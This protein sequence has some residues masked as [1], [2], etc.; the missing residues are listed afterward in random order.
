MPALAQS[1]PSMTPDEFL[2]WEREQEG[3]HEFIEGL[4]HGMSGASLTHE[5]VTGNLYSALRA[6]LG[7]RGCMVYHSGAKVSVE[8][9]YFYPDVVVRCAP[10]D[11]GTNVIAAP[12][13]IA[14]V[15]SPSTQRY[16]QTAK[17]KFYQRLP[18]LQSFLMVE[19]EQVCVHLYRRSGA[20]WMYS[21][22]VELVDVIE[23]VEPACSLR[24]SDLYYRIEEIT[25]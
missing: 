19:Q 13:L 18:T 20:G 10:R 15:L 4:I 11:R 7:P 21:S 25:S 2:A 1:Q 8:S 16:D 9:N 22:H 12:V 14:E 3:R 23:L 24:L 5:E 6:A 17:W